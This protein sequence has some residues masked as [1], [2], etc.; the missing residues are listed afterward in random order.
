LGEKVIA[1]YGLLGDGK[2]AVIEMAAAS[3]LALAP[4]ERRDPRVTRQAYYG[5]TLHYDPAQ[6]RGLSKDGYCHALAAEGC[7]L[8]GT[9]WPVYAAPLLNLYDRASPVPYRDPK[10]LQDYKNLKLPRTEKA[11]KETALVLMHMNLLGEKAYIDELVAAIEKVN[12]NLAAARKAWE[13]RQAKE[14]P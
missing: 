5:M 11:V 12:D 13:A 10:K 9:Y 6:A 8:C 1:R 3:G 7:R 4:V 2:T 14:K